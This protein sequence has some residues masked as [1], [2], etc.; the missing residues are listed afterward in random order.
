MVNTHGYLEIGHNKVLKLQ[1]NS[2]VSAVLRQLRVYGGFEDNVLQKL[3]SKQPSEDTITFPV[4]L[5]VREI[6]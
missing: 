3:T 2:S 5:Y 6:T 1:I 4:T